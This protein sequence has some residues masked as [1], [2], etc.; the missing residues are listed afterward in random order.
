MPTFTWEEMRLTSI[1]G[2][3]KRGAS[4]PNKFPE[5]EPSANNHIVYDTINCVFI[6]KGNAYIL[7]IVPVGSPILIFRIL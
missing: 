4:Y 2:A 7:L 5:Y 6:V 3:K 1:V